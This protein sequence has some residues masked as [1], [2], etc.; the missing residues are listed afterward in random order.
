MALL[1]IENV[2]KEY[3]VR[4]KKV[5]A[6][7]SVD[8]TI[9]EGEFVTVVGPSGCG[10]STLLNLIVG[11]MRSSMGR[12]VFRGAPIEGI[13]TKIGYVTQ[14]DNLLP[15]RTLIENVEIALEI[16]A[17]EKSARRAQAQ[18]LIDQVGLSGFEDHYPHEL[19]G[20][21]RQRAN[22]IR[23]LIYDPELILMDEPFGPLDAQTRIVL[24]DQLLKL[25]YASKKT[26]VFIT[27]DLIEAITLA[28]RVVLMSARPG[29]IKSIE[30]I[31]I[32]R[33]R[34]VFK[35]HEDAQ[36]RSAY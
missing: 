19:S 5:L 28:D 9:A 27:H 23:T 32:P 12:I 18:D 35:I 10:K 20:G 17:I 11:L 36:F 14:K 25:W 3:Q 26:I 22:I 33:P 29:R 16:R 24:Q 30:E 34:D 1:S 8:L 4:G 15:W 6:L 7:D 13:T 21:M 2:R 31:A